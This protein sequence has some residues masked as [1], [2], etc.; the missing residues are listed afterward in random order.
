LVEREVRRLGLPIRTTYDEDR[1][2][3][4]PERPVT[5]FASLDITAARAAIR[6]LR[7]D[8]IVR[9]EDP[10]LAPRFTFLRTIV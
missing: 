6:Q 10:G 9:G 3:A 5:P 7:G 4:E 8:L 1:L 2:L